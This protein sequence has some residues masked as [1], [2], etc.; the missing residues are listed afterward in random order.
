MLRVKIV[1]LVGGVGVFIPV[2]T[3]L[4]GGVIPTLTDVSVVT[5]TMVGTIGVAGSMSWYC[6]RIVGELSW[7]PENSALRVSTLTM[8]GDRRDVDFKVDELL[9]D[10]FL[11]VPT[12]PEHFQLDPYPSSAFVP[13]R[14]CG[15]TYVFMWG[16]RHVIQPDALANLLVQNALPYPPT[17]TFANESRRTDVRRDE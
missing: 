5:A 9:A 16:R 2:A 3:L 17:A 1:Q 14:I 13:L 15:K 12:L 7:R 11:E 4:Q 6:E 10:G 8:W